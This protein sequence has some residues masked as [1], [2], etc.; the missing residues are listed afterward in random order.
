MME[1]RC[2]K[3]LSSGD[4]RYSVDKVLATQIQGL[5]SDARTPI[6]KAG[7]SSNDLQF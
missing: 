3:V 7:H 4:G 1:E 5:S 2:F 6:S